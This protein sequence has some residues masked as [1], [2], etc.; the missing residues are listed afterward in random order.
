MPSAIASLQC[1]L[2][3]IMVVHA[4]G[5]R[6]KGALVLAR[7]HALAQ[8]QDELDGHSVALQ[9]A[10]AELQARSRAAAEHRRHADT[11]PGPASQPS[12]WHV[13]HLH[14]F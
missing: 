12:R 2:V 10:E 3:D 9:R 14:L 7:L 8:A 11:L 6:S 5:S 1:Y 13:C 4:G